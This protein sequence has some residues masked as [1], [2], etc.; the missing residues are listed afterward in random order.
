MLRLDTV[1][2]SCVRVLN[3]HVVNA[4][5][6]N[7]EAKVE[8]Y[9][10]PTVDVRCLCSDSVYVLSSDMVLGFFPKTCCFF[11]SDYAINSPYLCIARG[12]DSMP[13][14]A[15]SSTEIFYDTIRQKNNKKSAD[16]LISKLSAATIC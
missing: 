15:R 8:Q 10:R 1:G 3:S 16:S 7:L 2:G 4:A 5:L 11:V 9:F 14:R 6:G 13:I 12:M